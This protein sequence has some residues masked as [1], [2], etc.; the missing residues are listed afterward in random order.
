MTLTWSHVNAR[1]A[2]RTCATTR[3]PNDW[4]K[5]SP[6]RIRSTLPRPPADGDKE[7]HERDPQQEIRRDRHLDEVPRR[8]EGDDEKHLEHHGA[9]DEPLVPKL[10][11]EAVPFRL[12]NVPAV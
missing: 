7:N 5:L 8:A 11:C 12:G 1:L 6:T 2:P 3:F 9:I 10:G 4:M